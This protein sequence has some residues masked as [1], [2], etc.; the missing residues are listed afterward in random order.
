MKTVN[1]WSALCFKNGK[2]LRNRVVVPPMASQTADEQ[3]KVSQETLNHYR[4]LTES[5]PGL[6]IVEYTYV[7]R[8]GRS[9]DR[10]LGAH[11]DGHIDG[12]TELA[13]VIGSTGA[14]AGLQITHSGGKSDRSL[15][16][17][18]LMG[19]SGIAV[20]V[21]DRVL[22]VPEA[23]SLVQIENWH[24]AFVLAAGRAVEAGFDLI[25]LH[26]AHG[27]GLNQ[28]LSPITNQRKDDYGGNLQERM[29]LLL[30]V[31]SSIR[32]R[33]PEVL[34]SVRMP[35][36]DFYPGGLS[37]IECVEIARA[38]E[39]KGVD[40]IHVSSGIGGWRRPSSRTG[41]GYLVEE[42]ALIAQSVKTPVIGVGGIE[43]GA[44]IDQLLAERKVSLTAVGRAILTDPKRWRERNLSFPLIPLLFP[45][46]FRGPKIEDTLELAGSRVDCQ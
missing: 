16:G 17:G 34:L 39:A 12:L 36:Q 31:V 20:P 21:R 42:A 30:R 15:T 23:M 13:K 7:D 10:Q 40:L 41:E 4:R 29:K 43:S 14:L 1:R 26:A 35:G 32:S 24:D 6:L 19:P 38:L 9:E 3:G 45:L 46:H 5:S 37:P 25:E 8:S 18:R 27:Y 28:W 11:T 2:R 33:Y 22:E 44:F